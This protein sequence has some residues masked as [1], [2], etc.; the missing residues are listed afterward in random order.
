MIGSKLPH[1][2]FRYLFKH[3]WQTWL[4]ILGI[5]LGVAVVVAVDL[6]NESASRTFI[7]SMEHLPGRTT[8]QITA[9]PQGIPEQRIR[10]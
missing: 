4:S 9:G 8:Y 5:T 2:G 1:A 3:P 7:L 10:F 6:A